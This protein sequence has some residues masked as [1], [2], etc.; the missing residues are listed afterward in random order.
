MKNVQQES[1]DGLCGCK[2]TL[3]IEHTLKDWRTCTRFMLGIK[4]LIALMNTEHTL[5]DW[6]TCTRFMLGIKLLIALIS[7]TFLAASNWVSLT[8]KTIFSW[9]GATSSSSSSCTSHTQPILLTSYWHLTDILL[10]A[11]SQDL[12]QSHEYTDDMV[13]KG[14]D[15]PQALTTQNEPNVRTNA[16]V[17]PQT[18]VTHTHTHTTDM[19]YTYKKQ[20]NIKANRL[21]NSHTPQWFSMK[22]E[23]TISITVTCILYI[24]DNKH[25][26]LI[27]VD[28]QTAPHQT[29]HNWV[30]V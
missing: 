28:P 25:I 20:N 21:D 18:V 7:W 26:T 23:Y 6:R 15:I 14:K 4:L 1:T 12:Q 10:T 22:S 9:R 11:L 30:W 16:P 3:N 19:K 13:P 27:S 17:N 2:A 24:S 5:K 29:R 8:V